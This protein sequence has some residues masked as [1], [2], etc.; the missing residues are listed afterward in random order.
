MGEIIELLNQFTINSIFNHTFAEI[1]VEML[2][3]KP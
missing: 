1:A 3:Y 2:I